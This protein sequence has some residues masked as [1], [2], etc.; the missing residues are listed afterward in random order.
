M[1]SSVALFKGGGEFFP[2]QNNKKM[3]QK[4]N[5]ISRRHETEFI[6]NIKYLLEF[7]FSLRKK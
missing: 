1:G 5:A 2:I 6:D 4:W 3:N 7:I